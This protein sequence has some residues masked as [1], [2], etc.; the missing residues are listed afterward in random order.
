[1]T[2]RLEEV[3]AAARD[4]TGLLTPTRA[5]GIQA[6]SHTAASRVTNLPDSTP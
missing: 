4:G 2:D 6:P 1:M 5:V 3:I